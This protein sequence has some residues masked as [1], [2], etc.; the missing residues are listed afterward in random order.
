MVV[1][2]INLV[3][4]EQRPD[5]IKFPYFFEIESANKSI[6]PI[7]IRAFF[8]GTLGGPFFLHHGPNFSGS[9]GYQFGLLWTAP[10]SDKISIFVKIE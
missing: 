1:W 10:W 4:F 8:L 9:L 2:D 3:A 7:E 5:S 6:I